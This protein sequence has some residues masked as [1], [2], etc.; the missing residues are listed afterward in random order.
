EGEHDRVDHALADLHAQLLEREHPA[1]L[2]T[3]AGTE[4]WVQVP[5][6]GRELVLDGGQL[7]RR[8]LDLGP[9]EP[10]PGRDQ[11]VDPS[12]AV[13]HRDRDHRVVEGYPSDGAELAEH[14]QA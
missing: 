9:L 14:E 6:S 7:L 12:E 5:S 2:T 8:A 4:H 10:M 3:R 11:P 1:P 13:D